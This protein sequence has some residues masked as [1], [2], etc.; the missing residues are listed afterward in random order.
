M[1]YVCF[2]YGI[3]ASCNGDIHILTLYLTLTHRT[4]MTCTVMIQHTDIH[5]S[6]CSQTNV[7]LHGRL[8]L[9][10]T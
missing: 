10:G 9:H 3:H 6:C 4:H 2:G 1:I 7:R 8:L 5:H